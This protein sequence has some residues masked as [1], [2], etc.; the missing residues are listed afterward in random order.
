MKKLFILLG[1]AGLLFTGCDPNEELYEEIN[2]QQLNEGPTADIAFTLTD[3]DYA[4][5]IPND[6]E[7]AI[8]KNKRFGSLEEVKEYVPNI[9][10]AN[11]PRLGGKSSALV[12]YEMY[13]G[14]APEIS[15]YTGAEA[16]A[17]ADADYATGSAEAAKAGFFNNDVVAADYLPAVLANQYD[18]PED[19]EV[20][21]VSYKY[22]NKAY[23]DI[24]GVVLFN[25]GFETPE[26]F[27][28]YEKQ[29]VVGDETW[30]WS[31]QGGQTYAKM[32][33]YAGAR[34]AN[35]DWL[36]LS[37]ID[38]SGHSK[39]ILKISQAINYPGATVIGEDYAVKISTDYVDDVTTATWEDLALS[40]WPEG[41]SWSFVDSE[42]SLAAYEGE[43]VH[44]AFFY[45]S[46]NT[47][48]G[49]W[50]INSAAVEVG[51][52][53]KTDQINLF[54]SYDAAADEW[55]A[56][57]EDEVYALASVDY[58]AMGAPGKYDNFSSSVSADNYLPAFLEQKFPYAQEEDQQIVTYKYYS[59]SAKETQT[60]GDLY[61]FLNGN[62]EKYQSTVTESLQFGFEKGSWVPDNTVKYTLTAEDF[63]LIGT[64]FEKPAGDIDKY[65]N[66]NMGKYTEEEVISYLNAVLKNKFPNAAA[67]QKYLV[68]FATYNPAGIGERHLILNAE[69]NYVVVE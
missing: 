57:A 47:D 67:G 28:A 29:S 37:P 38:L 39:A 4:L 15:A 33:G 63:T 44:I 51:E 56:I 17:L 54:Y 52:T 9:L 3:A 45:R 60:R 32:T 12:T 8:Q 46:T 58:D 61:T 23:A 48:A 50:E 27:E 21:A 20:V 2:K 11:Y 55:S 13:R 69:G 18:A 14:F 25:E 43:T 36:I 16:Y 62:W 24:E 10:T 59:S 64:T 68:S 26:E 53:V 35:E 1:A 7:D 40:Q 41:N 42:A 19:G 66:I 22:A 5:A 34:Y 6:K 31:D 49:T 65:N 30:T